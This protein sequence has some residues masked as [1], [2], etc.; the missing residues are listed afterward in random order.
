MIGVDGAGS[1]WSA[2]DTCNA[3]SAVGRTGRSGED[4]VDVGDG[5][6]SDSD[7]GSVR[8]DWRTSGVDDG[9]VL[10][11]SACGSGFGTSR[12]VKGR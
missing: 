10:D 4:G 8:S 3:R 12:V 2:D 6:G 9:S 7:A 11:S 1:E 5:T